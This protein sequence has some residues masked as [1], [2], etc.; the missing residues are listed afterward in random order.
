MSNTSQNIRIP[1][2]RL[3]VVGEELTYLQQA[4]ESGHVSGDGTFTKRCH[5]LLE[6]TLGVPKALLTTSCTHALEMSALLL[7]IQPGDE[8]IVPDFTF[9]ST[10]NAFVLRGAKPVFVDIRPDTLNLDETLLESKITSKTKAIVPVHYAGVGCQ[11]DT[12][13]DIANR[14]GIAVVEDNAHGLFARYRGKYLGTFGQLATQSFHETKNFSCGE[15]GALL[16]NDSQFIERAEILREKGTNRS[17][18]FRGQVDKYSWVDIGSS[19]LLSD[20]LAGFLL[21]QLEAREIIQSR[22]KEIWETY[23]H[24]LQSWA[25]Q[26]QVR[27]PFIPEHCDQ[28]Y[29]MFYLLMPDLESRQ[30]LI[31]YL[32][33]RGILSV[34]HYL[35]LHLS[36]MG[37]KYGGKLGDCPVTESISD[38]LLRLPFY[39]SLRSDEQA[40][41]IQAITQFQ[42]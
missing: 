34:F 41:V 32:K 23:F 5:T 8:V 38:R 10:I 3:T 17:R 9:V 13:M 27:L 37:R 20:M 21:G 15:G 40:Q 19:Y 29:H 16:I 39:Y 2:N 1:F 28:S 24:E 25:S 14:Y 4:I 6:E 26:N 36:E 30:R 33:E 7:N 31:Q 42:P 22:R 18:F 12:I 35:P 11:M